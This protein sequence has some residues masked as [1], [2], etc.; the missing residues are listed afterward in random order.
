[1]KVKT[2]VK[3]ICSDCEI[4]KRKRVV[5]FYVKKI[6]VINNVKDK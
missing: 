6:H 2:S 5:R 4:V 3:K 1:M